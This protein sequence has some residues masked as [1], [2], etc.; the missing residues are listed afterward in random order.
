MASVASSQDSKTCTLCIQNQKGIE[1]I[2]QISLAP[3]TFSR[4]DYFRQDYI[5]F[6]IYK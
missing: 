6:I 3:S 1:E 2:Q 5:N 4:Q